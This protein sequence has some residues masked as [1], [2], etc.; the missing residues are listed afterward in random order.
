MNNRRRKQE[1][2]A[3]REK[4]KSRK[5]STKGYYHEVEK[6]LYNYTTITNSQHQEPPC[7]FQARRNIS[8]GIGFR[9][10]PLE[11]FPDSQL[12]HSDKAREDVDEREGCLRTW[13]EGVLGGEGVA[14]NTILV[15]GMSMGVGVLEGLRPWVRGGGVDVSGRGRGR[16]RRV[17]EPKTLRRGLKIVAVREGS[18]L[19]EFRVD[20]DHRLRSW[21][22]FSI[23]VGGKEKGEMG[24]LSEEN[25]E[26][27]QE[28]WE[29][30]EERGASESV[31]ARGRYTSSMG[32]SG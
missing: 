1:Q 15:K 12:S 27:W 11:L 16:G 20:D 6:K 31:L 3:G 14:G 30:R 2:R 22:D 29:S 23:G 32:V 5:T 18:T 25:E 17:F 21:W 10:K 4:K 8:T 26:Q 13:R 7:T 19:I 24:V 9:L 28:E